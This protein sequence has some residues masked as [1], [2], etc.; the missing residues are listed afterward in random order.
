MPSSLE[1]YITTGIDQID[2]DHAAMLDLLSLLSSMVEDKADNDMIDTTLKELVDVI[3]GHIDNED[4]LM[5]RIKYH[6]I[7]EHRNSH[8]WFTL[9]M[10]EIVFSLQT[11]KILAASNLASLIKHWHAAHFPLHDIPLSIAAKRFYR[12]S[13]AQQSTSG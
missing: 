13:R 5:I 11:D 1:R 12:H 3:C 10:S 9:R 6:N 7:S 2:R 8:S 4:A